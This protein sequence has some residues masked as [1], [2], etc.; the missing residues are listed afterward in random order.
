MTLGIKGLL[1]TFSKMIFPI[2]TLSLKHCHCAECHDARSH[3]LFIV[4]LSVFMLSVFMLNVIMQSVNE[5]KVFV[6]A[7]PFQRSIM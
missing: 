6:T 7:K 5:N 2:M 3:V 4:M 1:V